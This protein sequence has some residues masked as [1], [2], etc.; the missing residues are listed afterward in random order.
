M[1]YIDYE[2]E[3]V[4]NQRN[5]LDDIIETCI[6]DLEDEIRKTIKARWL[7]SESVDG[8][9]ITNKRTGNSGYAQLSYKALKISKNPSAGGNVDLTLTGSL[10]DKIQIVKSGNG[11]HEIISTDSKYEEIGAIY[12]F[13]EFGLN[14][15]EMNYFMK[16]LEDKV[17]LKM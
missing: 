7:K 13:D 16:I 4:K 5:L 2:L 14:D 11:N 9:N 12:G 10:G 17:N 1:E 6:M 8:G 3:Y 15:Q